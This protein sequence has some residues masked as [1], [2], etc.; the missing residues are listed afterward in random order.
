M[1]KLWLST[2]ELV[3]QPTCKSL[4]STVVC[5]TVVIQVVAVGVGFRVCCGCVVKT[6]STQQDF[7]VAGGGNRDAHAQ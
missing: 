6:M 2:Q 7:E 5:R 4:C 3:P 1:S